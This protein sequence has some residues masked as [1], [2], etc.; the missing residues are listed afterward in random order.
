MYA[1]LDKIAKII[2]RWQTWRLKPSSLDK[3]SEQKVIEAN[4]FLFVLKSAKNNDMMN[5]G[6]GM[7]L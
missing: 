3:H 6:K 1:V 7:G 5:I 2:I 4:L